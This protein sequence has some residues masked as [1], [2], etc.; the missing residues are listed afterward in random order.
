MSSKLSECE[1]GY[2]R[3]ISPH[4]K[5]KRPKAIWTQLAKK[6]APAAKRRVI[7]AVSVRRAEQLKEYYR[8]L[9][10]W[11]K[12]KKCAWPFLS[13]IENGVPIMTTC[14]LVPIDC[15]HSRGRLHELLLMQ[16]FWI[17]LCRAHHDM[18]K[19]NPGLAISYGLLCAKG[20]W[21]KVPKL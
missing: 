5:P 14:G 11:K 17:P 18:V 8:L 12:G 4:N 13:H 3:W 10:Q 15:H 2:R 21:N 19:A 20:D 1:K 6:N 16:E 7:R 9:R